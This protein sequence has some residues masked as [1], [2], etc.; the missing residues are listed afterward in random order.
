MTFRTALLLE[1]E[2]LVAM[3]VEDTLG[4][5]G[6]DVVSLRSCADAK[7]WLEGNQP[8]IAVVDVQLADGSCH[9]VVAKLHQMGVPFIVYSGQ[10]GSAFSETPFANGTWMG[11]PAQPR[12]LIETVRQLVGLAA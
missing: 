1:D 3:D 9:D 4:S 8:A 11:K 5:G 2:P 7:A 10:D 6:F 12:D